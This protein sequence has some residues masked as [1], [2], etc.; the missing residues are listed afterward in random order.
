MLVAR[1]RRYILEAAMATREE[2]VKRLSRTLASPA[3]GHGAIWSLGRRR[4][5]FFPI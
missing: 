2:I 3:D 5:M 4:G 1:Q